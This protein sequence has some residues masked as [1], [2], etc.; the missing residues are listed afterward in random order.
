MRKDKD[1]GMFLFKFRSIQSSISV[2]FSCLIL[3]L[4]T[5]TS[6]IS[7]QL[8]ADA[9][10]MNSK[11]YIAEIIQQVNINIQSYITNME[12]ISMLA[13]TNKD[14]KYYITGNGFISEEERRPYEKRISDLFQSILI[15]RKDIA[16]IMVFGYNNRFVS[17]RRITSLNTNSGFEEQPWYKNA[18]AEGG[19]SVISAPHVQ[20]LIQN[21][22][23]WVVSL[24]RELKSADGITGEGIFLVD[25]NLSVLNE[26]CSHINLGKRGYVFIID[27]DGNLVY[28]P[29]QK[30]INSNLKT[31]MIDQVKQSGSGSFVT[32]EGN[33][34]RIYTIQETHFGWKI[35]GVAYAS[36][37]IANQNQINLSYF[38]WTILALVIA[39]Y[40]SF[41]ISRHL[42]RPIK[43]LQSSMKQVEKGDFSIRSEFR[44]GN[45]IGQLGQTFNIMVGRIK[46][47]MN[48]IIQNEESK[49]KSEMKL[50]EAQINPHFLYNTLDSI[51]WMAERKK[52]E[53]VVLMTSS[54][55][56]LFRAIINK[57]NETVP[58]RVEIEH[59][60]NYLL[61]QTLRYKDKLDFQIDIDPGIL[62]I[63]IPKI[64]LQPIVENAIYHGIKN[65]LEPG[66][67]HITGKE[68]GDTIVFVV[69][70]NGVGMEPEKLDQILKMKDGI[71]RGIG[72]SNVHE[73]IKLF[74]H[75]FGL[76]FRSEKWE[77][78]EVTIV[79]PKC[80]QKG[81]LDG[82]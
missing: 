62:D 76:S 64:I 46:D 16:S 79:L 36:E 28:H 23:R 14:V 72:V 81:A 26:I 45:E 47:L 9:V 80:V 20:N 15:T 19:K 57:N 8:S 30:L 48:Q 5:I 69:A 13:S 53:E 33:K 82:S 61:I 22:Y 38:L 51:I 75:E 41:F 56:K 54:L 74:G 49:R 10:E 31:E 1:V 17:D 50:L 11:H 63:H 2:V 39:L 21:E 44:S 43:L 65:S 60:T 32:G 68:D 29:Q 27:K 4:I 71:V 66:L 42:S 67:V 78:T 24:S 3:F 12:D 52:H 73:R 25:L 77:G 34:K 58:V 37:L 7:Y 70:D 55:A 40:L 6:Y 18:K 59:I 35:V